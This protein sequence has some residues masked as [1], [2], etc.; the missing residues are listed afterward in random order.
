[1]TPTPLQQGAAKPG[2]S[3][4]V[5]AGPGAG[6]EGDVEKLLTAP[7]DHYVVQVIA[8]DSAAAVSG[9]FEANPGFAAAS[10]NVRIH[11]RGRDWHVGIAGL[12]PDYAAAHAAAQELPGSS[13]PWIRP[14]KDLKQAIL[15]ARQR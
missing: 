10:L 1:M 11:S 3:E 13:A 7:D 12:Y 2:R 14:V 15:A 6:D 8:A 9:Y 4:P 5:A